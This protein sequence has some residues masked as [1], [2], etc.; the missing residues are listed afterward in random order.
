MKTKKKPTTVELNTPT[1][2]NQIQPFLPKPNPKT[3]TS[4]YLSLH[5]NL[6]LHGAKPNTHQT[7]NL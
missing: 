7:H 4:V 2:K 3:L 5:L 1:T 6:S